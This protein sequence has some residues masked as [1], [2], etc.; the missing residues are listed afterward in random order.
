MTVRPAF[1]DFSLIVVLQ[2]IS[3]EITIILVGVWFLFCLGLRFAPLEGNWFRLRYKISRCDVIF[4]KQ[5]WF[6]EQKVL[7]GT[8]FPLFR[9]HSDL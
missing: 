4:S 2:L 3:F 5:H 6:D 8:P 9:K 7:V 1:I